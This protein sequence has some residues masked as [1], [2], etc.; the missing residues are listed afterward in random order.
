MTIKHLPSMI[1]HNL[2]GV[3]FTVA[4]LKPKRYPLVKQP[5]G[6]MYRLCP[7]FTAVLFSLGRHRTFS[8]QCSAMRMSQK[9]ICVNCKLAYLLA[10]LAFLRRFSRTQMHA[11]FYSF[12][13]C[14]SSFLVTSIHAHIHGSHHDLH[15]DLLKVFRPT[16]E[17]KESIRAA[18]NHSKAIQCNQLHDNNFDTKN[19]LPLCADDSPSVNGRVV[20]DRSRVMVATGKIKDDRIDTGDLMFLNF[21]T[22]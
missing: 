2:K 11:S 16:A 6:M 9:N 18:A 5:M 1:L 17:V 7:A 21:E 22:R 19:C 10:T 20:Q 12:L 13:E 8:A 4:S 15:T 14:I 3:M